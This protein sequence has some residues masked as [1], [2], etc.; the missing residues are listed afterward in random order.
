[1]RAYLCTVLLATLLVVPGLSL[2]AGP[3][4]SASGV[5][6]RAAPAGV[7]FMAGFLTLTNHTDQLLTLTRI[8]SPDFGSV[9]VVQTPE[10]RQAGPPPASTPLRLPAGQSVTLAP[11]GQ[12]LRI[13]KPVHRLYEGDLVTLLLSFSDGSSLTIMAPVRRRPPGH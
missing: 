10:S 2:A 13:T 9:N 8:T 6:V 3:S 7:E 1:M 5:W 4:V 11:G 12:Q